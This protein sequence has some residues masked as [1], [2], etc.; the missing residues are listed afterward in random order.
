MIPKTNQP[1]TP[2]SVGFLIDFLQI[3]SVITHKFKVFHPCQVLLHG[4][5]LPSPSA[6]TPLSSFTYDQE[7]HLVH[8]A[9]SKTQTVPLELYTK[10]MSEVEEFRKQL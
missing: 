3:Q 6:L 4:A 10:T 2:I 8:Q 7:A 5:V 9:Y 1:F